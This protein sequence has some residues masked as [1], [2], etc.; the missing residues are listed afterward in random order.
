MKEYEKLLGADHLSSG[1]ERNV[2]NAKPRKRSRSRELQEPAFGLLPDSYLM[3]PNDY[4]GRY[5]SYPQTSASMSRVLGEQP[6]PDTLLRSRGAPEYLPE[7]TYTLTQRPGTMEGY[8]QPPQVQIHISLNQ[9]QAPIQSPPVLDAGASAIAHQVQ[10]TEAS[11]LRKKIYF[12]ENTGINYIGLLIG[13]KGMYQKKLEEKTGCKILIRGRYNGNVIHRGS[14]K[15]GKPNPTPDSE[16]AQ[17]VLVLLSFYFVDN[18]GQRGRNGKSR[19]RSQL[20]N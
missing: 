15:D 3:P 10:A 12:P 19:N 17:H 5:P 1:S 18:R 11:K 8:Q 4:P 6:K 2:E 9:Q 14:Q 7:N 13:P 16:D 20:Y